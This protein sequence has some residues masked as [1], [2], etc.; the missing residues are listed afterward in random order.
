MCLA[1]PG[2][3]SRQLLVCGGVFLLPGGDKSVS[4]KFLLFVNFLDALYR[5]TCVFCRLPGYS[6]K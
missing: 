6:L 1:I 3:D 5:S 4:V 2:R